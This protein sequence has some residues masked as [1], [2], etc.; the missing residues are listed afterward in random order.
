MFHH[1][2]CIFF[3]GESDF[4][5]VHNALQNFFNFFYFYFRDF[6]LS[7]PS[8]LIFIVSDPPFFK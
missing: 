6:L 8:L 3:C 2:M 1:V 7:P 5:Y 4:N